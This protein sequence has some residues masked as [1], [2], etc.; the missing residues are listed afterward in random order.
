[1]YEE[2]E[3]ITRGTS[4]GSTHSLYAISPLLIHDRLTKAHQQNRAIAVVLWQAFI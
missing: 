3:V 4:Q 2:L 1:M